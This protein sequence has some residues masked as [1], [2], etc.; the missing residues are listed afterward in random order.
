MAIG[1]AHKFPTRTP[2][3]TYKAL[4]CLL[5][6]LLRFLRWCVP[7]K[8][9]V[10]W[11]IQFSLHRVSLVVHLIDHE[12]WQVQLS[13]APIKL[14]SNSGIAP[15]MLNISFPPD[16]LTSVLILGLFLKIPFINSVTFFKF[17]TLC[18][19]LPNPILNREMEVFGYHSAGLSSSLLTY[20]TRSAF[21]QCR[22]L[23]C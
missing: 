15:K 5:P 18:F 7:S 23:S 16:V 1:K 19:N 2:A 13:S 21:R 17:Q 12:R 9:R 14:R 10:S 22:F 20:N 8:H 3:N 6:W 4:P 11:L